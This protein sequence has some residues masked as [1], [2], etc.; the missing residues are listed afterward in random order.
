VNQEKIIMSKSIK[1]VKLEDLAKKLGVSKVTISKA[2][3]D[4][5]DI[6]VAMKEK[7]KELAEKVGYMPNFMAKGLSSRKSNIIGLVVPKIA[8]FFFASVIESIYDAALENNY[9]IVMTVSQE[10]AEREKKH[11]LSLLSMK[12]DGLIISVTQETQD[13]SIFTKVLQRKIP[14]VFIDRVPEIKGVASV[15]VD[16][17]GGA[18]SAV[19]HFIKK[20]LTKIGHIGGYHH[21]NIGYARYRGFIKAL[22]RNKIPLNRNWISEG[23]FGEED[24][25]SGFKK[26]LEKGSL[27]QAILAVTYPVALGIYEAASENGIRIPED[28]QI[29][30]FGNNNFKHP[31]PSVFNFVDQPTVQLGR[32]SV[33]LLIKMIEQNSD[34]TAENIELKTKLILRNSLKGELVA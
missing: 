1:P 19:E 20:G 10:S 11:I 34:N 26:I 22:N 25:Y 32:E 33:N 21:V 12:V 16:D 4:H 3:R 7:V 15:T 13:I 5:P 9:D 17:E 29:T 31:V 30:C 24:G 18:Y 8:H 6:S 23:G 2:L 28:I 27:P 14:L